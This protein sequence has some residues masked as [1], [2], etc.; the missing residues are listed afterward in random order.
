M[1]G[2]QF[3]FHHTSALTSS[4]PRDG[5]ANIAIAKIQHLQASSVG[6]NLS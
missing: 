1:I 3:H 5:A 2:H 4:E 6:F